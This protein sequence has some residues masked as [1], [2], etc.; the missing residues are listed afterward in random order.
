MKKGGFVWD[1]ELSYLKQQSVDIHNIW[2]KLG[3]PRMEVINLERI[4]IKCLYKRAIKARR[5]DMP[6]KKQRWQTCKLISSDVK[7]FWKG[8]RSIKNV[9]NKSYK[10]VI[11]DKKSREEICEGFK[12]TFQ[13]NF[14]YSWTNDTLSVFVDN[15]LKGQYDRQKEIVTDFSSQDVQLAVERLKCDKAVNG[16]YA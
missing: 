10:D 4:R 11:S 7:G 13:E 9:H 12:V 3:R 14:I 16:L 1:K 15:I 5:Q 2:K 6:S 8:W